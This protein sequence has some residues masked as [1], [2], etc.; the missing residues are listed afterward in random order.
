MSS[1]YKKRFPR[2]QRIKTYPTDNIIP[3]PAVEIAGAVKINRVA[4]RTGG[5]EADPADILVPRP[6]GKIAAAVIG[7]SHG[8]EPQTLPFG[9]LSQ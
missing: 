8:E 3:R 4:D 9:E 1:L 2:P 5:S 6:A 7:D